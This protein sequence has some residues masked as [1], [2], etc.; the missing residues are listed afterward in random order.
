MFQSKYTVPK[1][2][3]KLISKLKLKKKSHSSYINFLKQYNVIDFYNMEF[4]YGIDCEG[5]ELP[6]EVILGFSKK[7]DEDLIATNYGYLNRIPKKHIAIATVNYGDLLCLH[8]NG[9]IYH[10]D[11]EVNDLYFDMK[12]INGYLEQN[13]NL[14][15]VADSFDQFLSM[16]TKLEDDDDDYDPSED[17][18]ENPNIPF[19]DSAL[20]T[21]VEDPKGIFMGPQRSI[22]IYLKKL[23]LSE[24]GREVLA[25]LKKEGISEKEREILARL[26]KEGL[27][28]EG[29]FE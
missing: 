25:K 17:E 15:F 20:N 4:C 10:W 16:I 7:E 24:K 26:K 12:V 8:P 13:T 19:P 14:K 22:P 28:E 1:D 23:E 18:F 3:D 2:I 9:K 11:H 21:W 6:L 27:L 29:I 5:E